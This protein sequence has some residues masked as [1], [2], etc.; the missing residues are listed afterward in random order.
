[1]VLS[2]KVKISMT[3]ILKTTV[4]KNE[5]SYFLLKH[6]VPPADT[7]S[8]LFFHPSSP[9]SN[10]EKQEDDYIISHLFIYP[11]INIKCVSCTRFCDLRQT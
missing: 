6:Y 9:P 2:N 3:N 7:K 11:L 4:Q 5:I 1:M 10:G 8:H